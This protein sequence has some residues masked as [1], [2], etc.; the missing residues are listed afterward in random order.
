MDLALNT[1]NKKITIFTKVDKLV[2]CITLLYFFLDNSFLAPVILG[3]PIGISGQILLIPLMAHYLLKGNLKFNLILFLILFWNI[4]TIISIFLTYPTYGWQ[5]LRS[6]TYCIDSNYI[7]LASI[8]AQNN[9]KR[10]EFSKILWRV[11]YLGN[12]YLL[13]LP[14]RSFL[15][16]YT[17]ELTAFSGYS[18][19]ILFLFGNAP[20]ISFVLFFSENSFPLYGQ[21]KI[22]KFIS[23]ITLIFTMTYVKARY[24]YFIL[25]VMSFYTFFK[26]PAGS[27]KF[28]IYLLLGLIIISIT[29]SLGI[30]FDFR[31]GE[32]TNLRFF[33]DHFLSSF[34]ISSGN[35]D[36]Q[37][38]GLSLRFSWW[39]YAI[40]ELFSSFNNIIFG[41]GQGKPLTNFYN[42][43]GILIR[44]LHNSFLGIFARN[45]LLGISIFIILHIKLISNTLHNIKVTRN[46]KINNF[47]NT[48]FIFVIGIFVNATSQSTLESP[49]RAIPY[50][51]MF[52]LIGSYKLKLKS[53]K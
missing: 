47:Y 46:Q 52:G 20:F 19:P 7:I 26:K 42:Q 37:F 9:I 33:Y 14:L 16:K 44:D 25:I 22:A 31:G 50:Y 51:F 40:N 12:I 29:L 27:G 39:N 53:F 15:L 34:G 45:G 1:T 21:K 4:I 30:R 13:L 48:G 35:Q 8:I 3:I 17:P 6:S 38:G 18:I 32:I 43:N 49:I 5:S 24:N 23:F 36:T 28:L 11:L 2:F 10:E 41:L